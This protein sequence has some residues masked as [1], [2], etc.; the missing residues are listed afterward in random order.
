MKMVF[1]S[2]SMR[3]VVIDDEFSVPTIIDKSIYINNSKTKNKN[4]EIKLSSSF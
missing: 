2:E 3:N 1:L 4:N